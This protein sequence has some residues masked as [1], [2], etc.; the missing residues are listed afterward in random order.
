[1]EFCYRGD[2]ALVIFLPIGT[3]KGVAPIRELRKEWKLGSMVRW[4]FRKEVSQ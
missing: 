1:M 2:I 3:D 4:T